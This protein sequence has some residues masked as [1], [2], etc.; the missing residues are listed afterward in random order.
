MGR[1][2]NVQQRGLVRQHS[3]ET[4]A[5]LGLYRGREQF[6][7]EARSLIPYHLTLLLGEMEKKSFGSFPLP[8]MKHLLHIIIKPTFTYYY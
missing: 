2:P 7:G 5:G 4:G 1:A 6:L 3:R 8:G